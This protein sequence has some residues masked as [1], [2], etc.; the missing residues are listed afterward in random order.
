MLCALQQTWWTISLSYVLFAT[1]MLFWTCLVMI[2]INFS[3]ADVVSN[4]LKISSFIWFICKHTCANDASVNF[5]INVITVATN[6]MKNYTSWWFVFTLDDDF[7][8]LLHLFLPNSPLIAS[9]ML[10]KFSFRCI[11]CNIA[12]VFQHEIDGQHCRIKFTWIFWVPTFGRWSKNCLHIDLA[13][14]ISLIFFFVLIVL[15]TR[16]EFHN[17]CAL[18][19]RT[20]VFCL[21]FSVWRYTCIRVNLWKMSWWNKLQRLLSDEH[22]RMVWT[23][24]FYKTRPSRRVNLH[25]PKVTSFYLRNHASCLL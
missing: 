10:A 4:K 9:K 18:L 22:Q 3:P 1:I 13:F 8:I 21:V 15:W 2:V 17:W 25:L 7:G 24:Q 6:T 19:S 16:M 23:I 11:E 12:H 5:L 14:A 20:H